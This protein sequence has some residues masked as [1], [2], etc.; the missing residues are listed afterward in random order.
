MEAVDERRRKLMKQVNLTEEALMGMRPNASSSAE[1]MFESAG[2]EET[3]EAVKQFQ[4][5]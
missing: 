1:A 2:L 3:A 5:S 4:K